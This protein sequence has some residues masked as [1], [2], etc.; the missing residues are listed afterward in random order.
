MNKR[1][2]GISEWEAIAFFGSEHK[3]RAYGS[4][5]Y[6]SDSVYE[7]ADSSGLTVSC[8]IH[9]I[10]R[11][12]TIRLLHD[13]HLIY[14]WQAQDLQDICYVEEKDR[15][16]MKFV[17]SDRDILTLQVTPRISISRFTGR[18]DDDDEHRTSGSIQ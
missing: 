1:K 3:S 11:D 6:D 10:H 14:E 4:E 2:L 18:G 15:T 8:A 5:W 9:P 12:V 13:N 17:V 16:V 7:V